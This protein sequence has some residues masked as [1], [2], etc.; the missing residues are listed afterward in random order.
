MKSDVRL[1]D[2]REDN[3]WFM[4]L[5]AVRLSHGALMVR[6]ARPSGLGVGS[7]HSSVSL[8]TSSFDLGGQ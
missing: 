2:F 1:A 7:V 6:K 5:T 4:I 8:C 3:A